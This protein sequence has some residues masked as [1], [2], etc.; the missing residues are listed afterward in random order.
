MLHYK[1]SS[2]LA[3][4]LAS[5]SSHAAPSHHSNSTIEWG[6]C[7]PSVVS[8]PSLSCGFL[9]VPLD[10][11]DPSVGN[12][13]LALAKA[14]A[15]GERRGS[16]FFNP[17]GPGD[18][19]VAELG[20]PGFKDVLLAVTGGV[21]DIITWDPR[22]VGTLTTPGEI[23]CFDSLEEYLTFFNGTI[24]LTGIEETGNFTDPADVSALFAQ[25]PVVQKKYEELGQKC[26]NAPTGKYLKYI[27]TSAAVRD[28][29]SI[30]N[31]IDGPDAPINYYGISYGSLIGSWFVN[32]FPERVGRVMLDGIVNP[33]TFATEKP[34]EHF[35]H[36]F[37]SS[38][39]VYKGL[40]TGCALAGP[41]GCPA[42]SEGDG[43]LDI[44]AKVQEL[45]KA[46]HDATLVNASV[47]LTSGQFRVEFFAEMYAT[48]DWGRYM[49]ENFTQI[50]E[51]IKG[52]APGANVS[53]TKRSDRFV[54]RNRLLGRTTSNDSPSY[55]IHAISCGD[56]IDLQGVTMEEQFK[57]II[58]NTRNIS[59]LFGTYWPAPDYLCAYWPVRAV[60]RYQGPFNKKLA[61]K[62]I[63]ASN[64]YDPITPLPSAEEVARQLGDSAVLVKQNGFGHST[65]AEPSTCMRSLFSGYM[66]NGTL[67]TNNTLCEVDALEIFPG[68]TTADILAHLPSTDV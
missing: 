38:D 26:L 17:G 64:V 18:S 61:N 1:I 3:L 65:L 4:F 62:I 45:I 20:I 24:E 11:Q 59:H 19:G 54:R 28:M 46:A 44:D 35:S 14:N 51:T 25:A 9:E 37:A 50:V 16:V 55:S 43:P 5:R 30:A 58:N 63:V 13:R 33:V 7:D 66:A 32:M 60:E 57:G 48:A 52:E 6:P 49:K 68:V 31:A 34:S 12:A 47:P 10:Y 42:A 21:Y 39:N 53:L 56:A 29:V 67:P 22:G 15:T 36:Q 27:G 8:E 23:F 40:L 41:S 2:I